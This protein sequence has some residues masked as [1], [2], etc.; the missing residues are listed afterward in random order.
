LVQLVG[1][2]ARGQPF[3][4]VTAGAVVPQS[5]EYGGD[6]ANIALLETLASNTGG[7]MSLA[8][9]AAFEANL[10]SQGAVREIGLPLLWLA[11]LLLPFDI[12]LRRLLFAPDQVA[13]VLQKVGL[14][15]L[16]PRTTNQEPRAKSQEPVPTAAVAPSQ[17]PPQPPTNTPK[18]TPDIDRL[19]E[20]QERA[21]R[22]ARG[23]E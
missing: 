22:R 2:D 1:Q 17:P 20:A 18:A 15:R 19:R 11:L 21:R 14:G 3:G 12:A 10:R 8:P 5:A 23:E 13:A 7:R 16:A 9:A 4:A 6:G